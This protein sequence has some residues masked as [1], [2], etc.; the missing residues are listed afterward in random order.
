[1]G[2]KKDVVG[3]D[4]GD[5]R[6]ELKNLIEKSGRAHQSNIREANYGKDL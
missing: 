4:Q 6:P 3:Q 1:M 2:L 5:G